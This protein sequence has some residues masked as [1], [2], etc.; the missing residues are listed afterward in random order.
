VVFQL[1]KP[2][3]PFLYSIGYPQYLGMLPREAG[4]GFDPEKD[5]V[6]AGPFVF[7]SNQ[8]DVAIKFRRH[9]DYFVKGQ[10]YVDSW[11]LAII[12]ETSQQL[13]QFQAEKLDIVVPIHESVKDLRASNPKATVVKYPSSTLPFLFT[14][15]R[16]GGPF[17]D[18]RIRQALSLAV[19]RDALLKLSFDG[20]G[21]WQNVVPTHL[22][23]WWTDPKDAANMPSVR[24]FGTADRKK[25]L[26]DAV[27]LLKAAGYDEGRKLPIKYFYTPNAYGDRYNQWAEATQGFL[28][29][30]G[31]FQP[32][33]VP[34]DYRGEWIAAGGVFF[35]APARFPDDGVAFA[36]QTPVTD[37]HDFVF[38][39]LHSRSTRNH[40][41]INDPDLDALIDREVTT[42]DDT[43]R[44]KAIHAIVAR[45]N[46]RAYYAP[47][48]TGP[49]YVA[50]QPWM[51]GFTLSM[52]YGAAAECWINVFTTKQ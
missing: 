51:R 20:E 1:S 38:N 37:A 13:A 4:N 52:T 9:P 24:W 39:T 14:Q 25:N 31:V 28:K 26:A 45:T 40:S 18:E 50:L 27:A 3:A 12:P 49:A 19:D 29:E 46:D 44:V 7:E 2:Y 48:M 15:Q 11:T 10:P 30:T 43:E 41:G 17:K 23:R 47:V 22:G 21:W 5:M 8:P 6:G 34:T 35:G 33:T 32:T 16:G 42:I 36:L